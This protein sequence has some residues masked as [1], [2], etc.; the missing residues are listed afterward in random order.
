MNLSIV[1]TKIDQPVNQSTIKLFFMPNLEAIT[2][3]RKRYEVGTKGNYQLLH[4][5]KKE[6]S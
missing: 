3:T 5:R 4:E 1:E 6:D 2:T